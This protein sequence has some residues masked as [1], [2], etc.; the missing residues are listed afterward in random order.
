LVV[1]RHSHATN[2]SLN[3]P[4]L[5]LPPFCP[6]TNQRQAHSQCLFTGTRQLCTGFDNMLDG[7]IAGCC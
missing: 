4:P 5:P 2:S 3:H 1:R 6:A 7:A